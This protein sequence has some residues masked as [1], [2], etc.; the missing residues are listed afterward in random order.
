MKQFFILIFLA[1]FFLCNA[2]DEVRVFNCGIGGHTSRHGVLRLEPLL[3]QI[4]PQ[5]LIIG[6]GGNDALNSASLVSPADYRKNMETMIAAA[7]RHGVRTIMLNTM[8]PIID[9]SNVER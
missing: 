5:I 7:R 6:Y 1:C 2:S 4:R 3:S 9:L 8:N